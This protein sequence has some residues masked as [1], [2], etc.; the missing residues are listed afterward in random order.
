[1]TKK[2][3]DNALK[4]IRI[5]IDHID[6]EILS[7]LRKRFDKAKQAWLIKRKFNVPPLDPSRWNIL[8]KNI[9]S[10]AEKKS[11]DSGIIESI[12][13]ILHEEAVRIQLEEK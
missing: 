2:A 3:L 13:D 5:E 4:E 12:W 10:K 1:M 9:K 7:L 6:E 11:L 8:I